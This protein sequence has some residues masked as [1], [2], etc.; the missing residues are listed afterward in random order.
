RFRPTPE[1]PGDEGPD[2]LRIE[3]LFPRG[4]GEAAGLQ[5]GD[6]IVGVGRSAF[7]EGSLA[8][9]AEALV[10]AESGRGNGIVRL[11]VQRAGEE[12]TERVE[13]QIPDGGRAAA[14]PTEG[15]G[16]R[17]IVDRALAWLAERQLGTGGF[18]ETLS[19]LNGAVVQTSLAGLAWL[20]AG[21]DLGGGPYQ[22]HVK[23]AADFVSRHMGRAGAGGMAMRPGM[24][25]LDQTNWGVAH[26]AIFLGEL[27]ARS[28]DDDVR[29]ALEEAGRSLADRQEP[30]GGW[31]HGPGGP[32]PLGY[33]ELNIV[34]GLA[35]C[36]IG[37]AQ[38]SGWEPPAAVLERAEAYLEASSSG[39]GGVGYSDSPG[40]QGMGNIGR[41]AGA[42][43]GYRTLG[44][45]RSDWG[46]KMGKWTARNVD[47]VLGG[48]ASLMQHVLL[49]GVAA[50]AL[51]KSARKAFWE[52]AERDLVLARAP[53]GS[54]QPRPWRESRQ[55]GSNADV[56][57]GEVW[58]TAAWTIVLACE[59]DGEERPGL[60]AWMGRGG[61]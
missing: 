46:R 42:W 43:L 19:G 52:R 54:F 6:V 21:S 39:D 57:F 58:T 34:T 4:P 30:S 36:G 49:A 56:T 5:V 26:A 53:D 35:L 12:R 44:L 28:P 27:Q 25:G 51:G 29:Q 61:S 23:R 13:V 41:T 38:A 15:A 14:K 45:E 50:H 24:Q 10:R 7:Q 33:T 47:E 20:A 40:Q 16:R 9:L 32:N 31:A 11:L 18:P 1:G 37:L 59:G 17:A 55:M 8:P 60:P 3:L 2:A 22:E 48:H